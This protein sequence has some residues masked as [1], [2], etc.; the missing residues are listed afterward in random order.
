MRLS[1][2]REELANPSKQGWLSSLEGIVTGVVGLLLTLY[3]AW[4]GNVLETHN[5]NSDFQAIAKNKTALLA[6]AFRVVDTTKLEGIKDY[7][8][9]SGEV[10]QE[11][12][13]VYTKHL[14]GITEVQGWGWVPR[15][16]EA[17]VQSF[18]RQTVRDG[19]EG[20]TIWEM[21]ED[22][23]RIP[24]RKRE[25]YYPIKY[26]VPLGENRKAVGFDEGSQIDRKEA[27]SAAGSSG[28]STASSPLK[29]VS[30][31]EEQ[32]GIL[33]FKP[34][35]APGGSLRGFA[36][37]ILRLQNL[38]ARARPDRNVYLSMLLLTD[39]GGKELLSC[40]FNLGKDEGCPVNDEGEY[41]LWRP[42]FIFGKTFMIIGTAGSE[43]LQHHFRVVWW[44]VLIIGAFFS[45]LAAWFI[46][47]IVRQK[48][49]LDT[50]VSEQTRDLV[51]TKEYLLATINSICDGVISFDEQAQVTEMNAIAEELTGWS[52]TQARGESVFT[53][54]KTGSST[55]ENSRQYIMSTVLTERKTLP[56]RSDILIS[57]GQRVLHI[58]KSFAPIIGEAQSVLGGVLVFRDV[59]SEHQ[60]QLKLEQSEERHRAMFENNYSMQL[61]VAP[62]SGMIIDANV[63]ACNFYG[64]SR[65]AMQQQKLSDLSLC[66]S[67]EI[68]RML[69]ETRSHESP[70]LEFKQL[71]ADSSV[72]D[73]EIQASPIPVRG[74]ILLYLVVQ[75]ITAK[76]R[77][78]SELLATQSKLQKIMDTV[79]V[80]IVII[81]ARTHII[82]EVNAEARRMIGLEEEEIVGK[83]CH[84]F[85]CTALVGQCPISD[86]KK[87]VDNSERVLVTADGV[88][89]PILKTVIKI[90]IA[91]IECLLESF[92]DITAQK[93]FEQDII[94]SNEKMA[95]AASAARFGVFDYDLINRVIDIDSSISGIYGI[96]E[97]K[98]YTPEELEKYIHPDDYSSVMENVSRALESE[99]LFTTEHRIIKDDGEERVIRLEA[100]ILRDEAGK[101]V[102]LIGVNYDTT[103]QRRNERAL[104]EQ[105]KNFR[106]FVETI[107]DM[108]FIADTGGKILYTNT[109]LGRKLGYNLAQLGELEVLNLY[110]S[111]L[112]EEV[113]DSFRQM[114]E[115]KGSVCLVP[116]QTATGQFIPIESRVWQGQ[117]N[118]ADCIFGLGK[119]LSQQQEALQRFNKLFESNPA[120]M[121]ICSYPDRCFT[122]VNN[123]F[124]TSIGYTREEILGKTF[125]KLGIF[126]DKEQQEV[127]IQELLV[128]H[129]VSNTEVK[130]CCKDGSRVDGIFSGEVI[131]NQGKKYCL[132]VLVDITKRKRTEL[133]L[134]RSNQELEAATER[135]RLL[136][137]EAEKANQA[138]SEFL[139]NMS[140]EIRTP[141][142]GVIGMIELLQGTKLDSE[143]MQFANTIRASAES[144]LTLIND[145]LDYSKIEANRL[146][147]EQVSFDLQELLDNFAAAMS[148]QAFAKNL[149][150]VCGIYPEVPVKLSGDP[151]R[152]KQVLINLAGNAIKFTEAGSVE[153]FVQAR[154]VTAQSVTLDFR[155][156]D[157]GIG[158]APDQQEALFAKFSQVDNSITR[159]YGGTG[160]GLAISKE[161]VELM[162]GTIGVTSV[163]GESTEFYFDVTLQRDKAADTA[164]EEE[165]SFAGKKALLIAANDG[166]RDYLQLRLE[167]WQLSTFTAES[168]VKG[169]ELLY[170]EAERGR[171]FDLLLLDLALPVM[172]GQTLLQN[173][174][175]E[176]QFNEI[177]LLL[178]TTPNVAEAEGLES[179]TG[180]VECLRKPPR[181]SRLKQTLVS[182]S[183]AGEGLVER[184]GE[185]EPSGVLEPVV[186]A[187]SARLLLVEDNI[188]NQQVA[189]GML[190]RFGLEVDIAGN[191]QVALQKLA[192][193]RYDLVFMDI[194]MPLMDGYTAATQIRSGTLEGVDANT[195]IIAMT[196]NAMSSDRE[197]CLQVGM[198]DYISKPI[199]SSS[200][201]K[202]IAEYLPTTVA[203]QESGAVAATNEE[204]AATDEVWD[205]ER[206]ITELGGDT[207]IVREI[208]EYALE[209]WPQDIQE[210]GRLIAARDDLIQIQHRAHTL[211]GAAGNIRALE[212]MRLAGNIEKAEDFVSLTVLFTQLE[213][214]LTAFV[215]VAHEEEV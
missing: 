80:G 117:W 42:V 34:V 15:V 61:L 208:L 148:V 32:K 141:M 41:V 5:I 104:K 200:L 20:F 157:T 124:L 180:R 73:V 84:N 35:Y 125:G 129:K 100:E 154:K 56:E 52:L 138:K 179:I 89:V 105:E 123:A 189:C 44:L 193:T 186:L 135:A 119:D 136:A 88:V 203:A 112:Q 43:F 79:H 194:Q 187:T 130:L 178:F 71:K 97:D 74:N 30:E 14:L 65:E 76:K 161:L 155:V 109:T 48:L 212:V 149:E 77:A 214:A 27:L 139:A 70:P 28:L 185:T 113:E 96:A 197:R 115:G 111:G 120:L 62:E 93:R 86:L 153:V 167:S 50:I 166:F 202:L 17:E 184:T 147:L 54:F 128:Y 198:N 7:F 175:N 106:S 144:L 132:L 1:R 59:S 181:L 165:V 75:D 6:E 126:E 90:K 57:R 134:L 156:S 18:L 137:E 150:F 72:V 46:G 171:S 9:S 192:Q 206:L 95:L 110:Y 140:H 31:Q 55:A 169:L 116:M 92:V 47:G 158:I 121:A 190:K 40:S 58:V 39:Q 49:S 78:Q 102:R 12:F 25:E 173:I 182:L 26:L 196:A 160:L 91:G 11:E 162:G 85:I 168:G 22:G 24:A 204:M 122:E 164:A 4:S 133:E 10:T 63:A 103:E 53:V 29:L 152:L 36:L 213:E 143:Q 16:T 101:A 174:K 172:S 211:K 19:V 87:D 8:N 201:A 142:N 2:R 177:P 67:Q 13:S 118:G 21:D 151:G 83:L 94:R 64:F 145:I 195:V 37:V 205:K 66:S 51:A 60:R 207:N 215:R 159:K 45:G 108:I 131:E 146:E 170:A 98:H 209:Y 188:T 81:D 38:L 210:L 176:A 183:G 82:R 33:V 163:V 3:L 68:S 191:G 107:D 69:Q 199:T 127:I 23:Q 114:I 99:Q